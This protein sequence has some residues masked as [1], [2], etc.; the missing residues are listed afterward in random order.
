MSWL[1]H[2]ANRMV[3]KYCPRNSRN[4][5]YLPLFRRAVAQVAVGNHRQSSPASLNR[6][7]G[8]W[9]RKMSKQAFSST[10]STVSS[11]SLTSHQNNYYATPLLR[12]T[13]SSDHF[14]YAKNIGHYDSVAAA[15]VFALVYIPLF[16]RFIPLLIRQRFSV[17]FTMVLFCQIRIV[18]FII[19]AVLASS[20]SAG[21]NEGLFIADQVLLSAGFVGLLYSAYGLVLD[22]LQPT[23]TAL[24]M[25]RIDHLIRN[26]RLFHLNMSLATALSIVGVIDLTHSDQSDQDTGN[27]LRKVGA[28]I[29]L[30]LT[31]ITT[32][33]TGVLMVREKDSAILEGSSKPASS[34][35]TSLGHVYGSYIL[36]VLCALMLVREIF[37]AATILA[38]SSKQNEEDS[39]ILWLPYRRCYV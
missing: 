30:A 27:T 4:H 29:L 36:G 10:L 13:M 35:L 3:S 11:S 28:I 5:Y 25:S 17:L 7:K 16:I 6:Y 34:R 2:Y 12:L 38:N 22:R 8:S 14:N 15:V 32:Y 26:R 20:D 31:I 33:L 1:D 21:E 18:S 37:L 39:G 24:P 19:R 23:E 9:P